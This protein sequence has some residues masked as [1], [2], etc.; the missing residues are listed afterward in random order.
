[1]EVSIQMWSVNDV[2]EKNGIRATLDMVAEHGYDGVEFAGFGGLSAEEMQA[3]LEKNHLYA[4]GSHTGFQN[5][6]IDVKEMLAYHKVIGAKYMIIPWAKMETKEDVE[7][8]AKL[9]NETAT[10][11]K[12]Y[13]V[14]VGYHNHAH[15]FNNKI[16]GKY[17]LDLLAE[18]TTDDV[19]FEIDVYWAAHAG[20]D[21][22]AYVEKLGKRVELIHMKQ[23]ADDKTNVLLS[24]GNIDFAKVKETAKYAK[25]FIVEQEGDVDKEYAS[26]E[27]AK[28]AKTL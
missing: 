11:A 9:L 23:I 7:E 18:L 15:E 13:G 28:F 19:V 12:E 14:K 6:E 25:Y 16:D 27:N 8:M 2:T 10:I 21:P 3:E 4:V 22:Y 20:V 26:R 17:A 5:P 1:M 24:E